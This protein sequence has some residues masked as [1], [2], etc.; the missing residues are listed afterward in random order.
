MATRPPCACHYTSACPPLSRNCRS[1][2][3]PGTAPLAL[4]F[5][6]FPTTDRCGSPATWQCLFCESPRRAVAP[7]R[8]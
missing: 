5:P 1:P 3:S 7:M 4:R 2:S 8:R 6:L